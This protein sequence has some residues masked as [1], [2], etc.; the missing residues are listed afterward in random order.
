MRLLVLI[1]LLMQARA[2]A[3]PAEEP[4]DRNIPILD[5]TQQLFG[6]QANTV[7]NRLDLF[8]ADQRADDELARSRIRIRKSYEIRERALM[9]TKTQFRFN[10]R[11]PNLEDKFK[12]EFKSKKDEKDKKP[13]AKG[14]ENTLLAQ[15]ELDRTWQFRGDVGFNASIPPTILTRGRLRKNTTSGDIIHRFVEELVWYSDKDWQENTTLDSDL[16]IDEDRLIRFRNFAD[17]RIT[18]HKFFTTHGP[19]LFQRISDDEA[20]AYGPSLSTIVDNGSWYVTNY[21]LGVTYRRNLYKQWIY[22]DITTGLDFPKIWSF[23]RTPFVLL[24]L[25]ALFGGI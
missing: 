4:R 22:S 8:F 11:L 20:I 21:R 6:M 14:G 5:S 19:S 1:L 10:I 12:F 3:S 2:F 23:R 18:R 17:W 13:K 7:A 25:E 15:N 9:V 24:Q 16:P